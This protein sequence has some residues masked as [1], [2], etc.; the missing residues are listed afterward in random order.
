MLPG[1]HNMS[2]RLLLLAMVC[3][4]CS[5]LYQDTAETTDPLERGTQATE[6]TDRLAPQA[7]AQS[8]PQPVAIVVDDAA[9]SLAI[10][11]ALRTRLASANGGP[12]F[13]RFSL[14]N[15]DP[16]VIESLITKRGLSQVITIGDAATAAIPPTD[17]RRVIFSKVQHPA[18]FLAQG[19]LGV[20]A[21]PSFVLQLS[22]WRAKHPHLSTV[23]T[24][25]SNRFAEQV[26]ALRSAAEQLGIKIEAQIVASDR[27]ASFVLQDLAKRIDGLIYLPDPHIL[28]PDFIR[29]A[30]QISAENNLRQ[31]AYTPVILNLPGVDGVAADPLDVAEQAE[32]L[33]NLAITPEGA[34]S[35]RAGFRALSRAQLIVS[36]QPD[37]L[38]IVMRQGGLGI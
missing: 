11:D 35:A 20:A 1:L 33:L 25:A 38:A 5:V 9:S 17:T 27:E 21:V 32:E 31:L 22:A 7:T 34:R 2:I 30:G 14:A 24:L 4:G 10:E 16:L 36:D 15:A 6:D 13:V 12:G 29:A 28:S 8:T 19:Y 23:G 3:S 18:A 37:Q 26:Q